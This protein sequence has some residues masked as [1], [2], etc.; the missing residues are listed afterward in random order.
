[1]KMVGGFTSDHFHF[2]VKKKI[3]FSNKNILIY[4]IFFCAEIYII[5]LP[6]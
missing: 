4:L 5:L 3:Y 2:I 6:K 1:M